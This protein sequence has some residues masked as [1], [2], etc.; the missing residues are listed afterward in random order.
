MNYR[1]SYLETL[2]MYKKVMWIDAYLEYPVK[3]SL[4]CLQVCKTKC[5]FMIKLTIIQ[6]IISIIYIHI[7][8][9]FFLVILLFSALTRKS[10]CWPPGRSFQTVWSACRL[11][12][13]P[14]HHISL[15]GGRPAKPG[16]SA[17]PPNPVEIEPARNQW[18]TAYTGRVDSNGKAQASV[19]QQRISLLLQQVAAES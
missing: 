11:A 8:G 7:Q 19:F 18:N 13:E 5:I 1:H 6:L 2:G 9:N 10:W 17:S 12:G 16:A 4:Y 14:M 15:R 3:P